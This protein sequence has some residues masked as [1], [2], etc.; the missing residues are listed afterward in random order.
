MAQPPFTFRLE[1]VRELRE[2]AEGQAKEQLAASLN[3]RV[4]GAAMLAQAS[5]E[6]ASAAASGRPAEGATRNA[7]DLLAH[8]RWMQALRREQETKALSLDRL[9]AEVDARRRTLTDRGRDREVLERLKDRKAAEH[10]AEAAR[11]ES[12]ELDEIAQG[13]HQR[14]AA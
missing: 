13:M 11:R 12:A 6:L 3:Q 2:H 10:A 1:R 4:R 8:E 14:R 9:D 7:A 5:D